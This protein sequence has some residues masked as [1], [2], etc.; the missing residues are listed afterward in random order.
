MNLSLASFG[1]LLAAVP[2]TDFGAWST[3]LTYAL[4]GTAAFGILGIV[5]MVVGFKAFEWITARLDVE[6]QLA[7]G[8]YAVAIVVAAIMLSLS[9][10]IVHSMS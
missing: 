1:P 3:N 9:W 4:A 6:K 2:G 5:L 10:I 7:E 8:N